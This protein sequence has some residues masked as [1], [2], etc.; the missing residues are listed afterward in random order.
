VVRVDDTRGDHLRVVREV[1]APVAV[2]ID[3]ALPRSPSAAPPSG[4]L[5]AVAN[6]ETEAGDPAAWAVVELAVDGFVTGGVADHR[7]V[8]LVPVPRAAPPTDPGTP[9]GG[10]IWE[11][12]VTVRYRPADHAAAPGARPDDPPTLPSLLTQQPALVFDAG[13]P[14]GSL[15]RNL[16]SGGPL[17]VASQPGPAPESSV[18]VVRPTP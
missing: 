1:L 9:A 4:S 16:T 7:G 2:P 10:P 15:T 18:L 12:T 14:V 17:V 8:V 5:V 13:S 3:V 6:L 11:A